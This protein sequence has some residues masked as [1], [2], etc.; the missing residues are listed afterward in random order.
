M[1]VWPNAGDDSERLPTP[2]ASG[3]RLT[4]EVRA[5]N[6][7]GLSIIPMSGECSVSQCSAAPAAAVRR[8]G[9]RSR[10]GYWQPYCAEHARQR[11]VETSRGCLEWVDG[12]VRRYDGAPRTR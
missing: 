11:G 6:D 2:T 8:S 12:F 1:S 7:D 9:S 5:G 10:P 4:A 3:W